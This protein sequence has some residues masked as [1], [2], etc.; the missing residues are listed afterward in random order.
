M[1]NVTKIVFDGR[2]NITASGISFLNLIINQPPENGTCEFLKLGKDPVTNGDVWNHGARDGIALINTYKV[3]CKDWKDPEEH[4]LAK[5][6]FKGKDVLIP[7][8]V[9]LTEAE[10]FSCSF[11][12]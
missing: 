9:G 12:P 1:L 3:V 6:V 7:L 5:Y 8:H 10:L 2:K 4:S 11:P